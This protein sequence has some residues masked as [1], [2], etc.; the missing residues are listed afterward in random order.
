L[1]ETFGITHLEPVVHVDSLY[2]RPALEADDLIY[3]KYESFEQHCN[4][5]YGYGSKIS[6]RLPFILDELV[7]SENLKKE[8]PLYLGNKDLF[9]KMR[10]N[11]DISTYHLSRA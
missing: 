9:K 5:M 8:G 2:Y 10:E 6:F 4:M 11:I 1:K 7:S 3:W